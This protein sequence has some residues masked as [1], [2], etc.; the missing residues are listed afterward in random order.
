MAGD[1]VLGESFAMSAI[2]S[3]RLLSAVE[4]A[5]FLN[6][7]P[8][9][10]YLHADEL[11]AWRLGDGPKARLRF[12]LDT[13]RERLTRCTAGSASSEAETRTVKPKP[14]RRR[15]GVSAQEVELLPIRDRSVS[16]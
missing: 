11:G 4:L 7:T 15:V 10:V 5:A 3:E 8:D 1:G 14:A 12:D 2:E 9:Y 6:V 16:S 13:V